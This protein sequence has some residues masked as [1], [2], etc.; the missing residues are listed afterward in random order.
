[1]ERSVLFLLVL[2]SVSVPIS[3]HAASFLGD[4]VAAALER[5]EHKIRYDGTY[6][7]LNYPNGDV[8]SDIGVCTDVVIRSY[9]KIGV[10]LQVLVHEDMGANFTQY[11]SNRIWGLSRPDS[12]ID[13]GMW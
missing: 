10:D 4:L 6:H 12:N 11:P 3:S 9:R 1:M 2:F 13:P 5:T 7:Q 8:P